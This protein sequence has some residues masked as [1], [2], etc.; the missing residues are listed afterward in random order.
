MTSSV[1]R[2]RSVAHEVKGRT[3][4]RDASRTKPLTGDEELKDDAFKSCNGSSLGGDNMVEAVPDTTVITV[5]R[6]WW[7]QPKSAA[8]LQPRTDDPLAKAEKLALNLRASKRQEILASKRTRGVSK[9]SG[10]SSLHEGT[11]H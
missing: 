7:A 10:S 6:S 11:S 1:R 2:L 5:N 8:L 9:H 4:S 3:K